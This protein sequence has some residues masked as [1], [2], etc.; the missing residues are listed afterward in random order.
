MMN[1][2]TDEMT[3]TV[4]QIRAAVISEMKKDSEQMTIS[5]VAKTFKRSQETI[6]R[7][8]RNGDFPAPYHIAGSQYWDRKF[9]L[10]WIKDKT[11]KANATAEELLD[12]DPAKVW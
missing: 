6:K 3:V 10:N 2:M 1:D 9:I 11:R 7:W 12:Y 5:E 4:A 8:V